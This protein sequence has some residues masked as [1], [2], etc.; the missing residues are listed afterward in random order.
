MGNGAQQG[1]AVG[2]TEDKPQGV[3]SMDNVAKH[4]GQQGSNKA[5]WSSAQWQRFMEKVN[6]NDSKE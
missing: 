3:Y 4:K 5:L 1:R 6:G 2:V